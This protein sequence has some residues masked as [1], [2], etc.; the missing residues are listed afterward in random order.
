[1]AIRRDTDGNTAHAQCPKAT[2]T[3]TQHYAKL[4]ASPLQQWLHEHA[5]ILRY[6]YIARRVTLYVHRLSCYVIR[7]SPVV[8]RY[9]SIA[10]R[11]TLYVHRPSCYVIRT[12]PVVLQLGRLA[13]ICTVSRTFS[14]PSSFSV[15]VLLFL[16]CC[17]VLNSIFYVV[18][19]GV[20]FL[21]RA[22]LRYCTPTTHHPHP[23]HLLSPAVFIFAT[24]FYSFITFSSHC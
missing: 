2:V 13:N 16:S 11:V 20:C 21:P 22:T 1:M 15:T 6:T 10:R 18:H 12:S 23:F 5:A 9:T 4:I 8:L 17:S 24:F 7:T 3:H 14:D 19:L